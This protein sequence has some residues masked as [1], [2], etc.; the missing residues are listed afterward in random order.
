M[1]PIFTLQNLDLIYTKV[2]QLIYLFWD[3]LRNSFLKMK[4]Y[5]SNMKSFL[6]QENLKILKHDLEQK[7]TFDNFLSESIRFFEFC[8]KK[9]LLLFGWLEHRLGPYF[10][11]MLPKILPV[12]KFLNNFVTQNL[13]RIKNFKP[14]LYRKR[15]YFLL[16][17]I[18][19]CLFLNIILDLFVVENKYGIPLLKSDAKKVHQSPEVLPKKKHKK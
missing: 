11:K 12:L 13:L 5:F 14:R 7:I 3:F 16:I 18:S 1:K 8:E 17:L 4:P 15:I 2:R 19:L 10:R 6:N 9:Y